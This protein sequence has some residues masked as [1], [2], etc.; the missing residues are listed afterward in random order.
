[1]QS[2]QPKSFANQL[3]IDGSFVPSLDGSTIDV[4]NPF[5]NTLLTR[6]AE[7]KAADVDRAVV[8]ARKAFPAWRDT[9]HENRG[10][11]LL[12]LADAMEAH[13]DELAE[14]ESLDTGH[15]VRDAKMLDVPR[16]AACVRYFGGMADKVFG[17]VVPTDPGF[18][19]YVLREPVG[20]VGGIIPWNFPMLSFVWKLAP[21]LACG[22]CVV[23][24]PSEVT[25]LSALRI[26]QLA[27][28]VGFP[29]GVI[30]VIPGYGHTAGQRIAEHPDVNKVAFTGSTAVGR[31]ILAASEG[32]LKRVQLELGGKG[33]NIVFE[34]C[35][36]PQAVNGSLFAIFHNQGQ[37]CI[38]GS[39]LIVHES[40]A[41]EFVDRFAAVA[42][43]IRQGDP[44]NP[45]TEMGP[46][47]SRAHQEKVLA[48]CKQAQE[49]GNVVIGGAAPDDAVLARGNFVLPTMVRAGADDI[50]FREEVFGPFVTLTT[51][52]D[53]AEA[54]HLANA[55]RYGLG[56]G[57]W[58][59]NLQRAHRVGRAIRAGMVWIN[60]YKRSAPGSPF[61]G[62]GESGYGR[63]LGLEV[64]Q[65]YT[66]PKS[67]WVNYDHPTPA[68]YKR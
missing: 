17:S 27:A 61:G 18:L 20:I 57:L 64:L 37:A 56:S 9:S 48:F 68:F 67:F 6:I 19:N 63:D 51:F 22:N 23:L 10:R 7:A 31:K 50:F 15:P 54:I 14:L 29:K 16:S 26:A 46:L 49:S 33:P 36:L 25:P 66:Y 43:T 47:A 28:E 3:F 24:K 2:S 62:V 40:I 30:N 55:T 11:L 53:E 41:D 44:L 39:R 42:K 35:D 12:K 45:E 65:E 52:K 38:A 13:F 34:D 5:D 4:L 8:A 60:C 58:T 59:N 32:N 21:A 1:M